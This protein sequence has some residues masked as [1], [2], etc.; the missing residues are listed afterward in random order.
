MDSQLDT[1]HIDGKLSRH[2]PIL[3]LY[4]LTAALLSL[5]GAQVCPFIES[6]SVLQ[7]VL[8]VFLIIAIQWQA[9]VLC[10]K[11]FVH[12]RAY[13]EHVRRR[14]L[15]EWLLFASSGI[16]L[17]LYNTA[18]YDFPVESGLK[19]VVG[20]VGFGFYVA[21]ES[22]LIH[23][24]VMVRELNQRN[25]TLELTENYTPLKKKFKLFASL[26]FLVFVFILALIII[27]DLEWITSV[28]EEITIVKAALLIFAEISFVTSI[29]LFACLRVISNFS[30]NLT[31]YVDL[32]KETLK[33][34]ASGNLDVNVSIASQD[35]LADIA[36]HTNQMI[37]LLKLRNK[38]VEKTQDITILSLAS[39][40]ETRDNETGMHIR[41]TQ[42]YVKVLAEKLR[43]HPDFT[44]ELTDEVIDL[45]YKSAPLHDIGKVG[46][47]DAILLKPGKLTDD[48]F[49]IMK[50]HAR[51]GAEALQVAIGED[52]PT[53]FLRFAQ[54]IAGG[55]HEKW[56][57][58]GYPDG[59]VGDAIPLSARLMAVADVYDALI[60]KRVY[61]PS[62][63]HEKAM[64]IIIEGKGTHFD[65]RVVDAF[66]AIEDQVVEIARVYADK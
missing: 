10:L 6:L 15:I 9:R 63:S 24:R 61:K 35:E 4:V 49:K 37:H 26:T 16:A 27:K 41:R 2:N 47:P 13:P 62:F 21:L 14:F 51:L 22:A 52:A 55:H 1:H 50:T 30:E 23:E 7:T 53:S 44:A 40:A 56:N 12:N 65:P 18:I 38:E 66:E 54:E 64:G 17:T 42:H 36:H 25:E 39:L 31:L 58:A 28:G 45:L 48:E 8:P 3:Q 11:T 46:I 32:E 60:S 59:L 29:F 43:S 33:A 20:L 5:Y 19:V 57:G 34:A